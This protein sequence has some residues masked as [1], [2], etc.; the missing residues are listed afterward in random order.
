MNIK[1]NSINYVEF[2]ANDLEKIKE[3]YS[4]S[5]AGLLLIMGQLISPFQ[6]VDLREDLKKLKMKLQMV[7]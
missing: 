3:F 2:K 1:D 7:H 4:K 6:K 5:F